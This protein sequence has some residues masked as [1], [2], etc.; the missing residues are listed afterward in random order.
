MQ[1][2][3]FYPLL[4]YIFNISSAD[5]SQVTVCLSFSPKGEQ[6]NALTKDYYER[7]QNFLTQFIKIAKKDCHEFYRCNLED[8]V[9]KKE[10][11]VMNEFSEKLD[12]LKKISKYE[13]NKEFNQLIN[14]YPWLVELN[15]GYSFFPQTTIGL[16][17]FLLQNT[18]SFKT[19]YSTE[20]HI[21]EGKIHLKKL[22]SQIIAYGVILNGKQFIFSK[23]K[24]KLFFQGGIG[25]SSLIQTDL[26]V[27]AFSKCSFPYFTTKGSVGLQ[28]SCSKKIGFEISIDSLS[29]RNAYRYFLIKGSGNF[30]F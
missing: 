13:K 12:T 24:A 8:I 14:S 26:D 30:R 15:V 20:T 27:E 28:I 7:T 25:F 3:L 4:L 5:L 18:F 29:I 23:N 21:T 9:V 19:Y 10:K 11:N 1:Y 16:S 6:L 22:K 2:I 17:G